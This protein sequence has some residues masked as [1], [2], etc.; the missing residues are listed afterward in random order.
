MLYTSQEGSLESG[1]VVHPSL[2]D[3]S[4]LIIKVILGV[5]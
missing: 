5:P 3:I 1:E 4:Q 2:N